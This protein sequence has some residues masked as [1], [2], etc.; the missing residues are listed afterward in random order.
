MSLGMTQ[1]YA[2]SINNSVDGIDD[3]VIG[4]GTD[5]KAYTDSRCD[6]EITVSTNTSTNTIVFAWHGHDECWESHTNPTHSQHDN[7]SKVRGDIW[8][9]G[10]KHHIEENGAF[11]YFGENTYYQNISAGDEISVDLHWYYFQ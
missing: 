1:A 3:W 9:D 11:D 2:W 6:N 7:F 8:I 4:S 10:V 5:Y